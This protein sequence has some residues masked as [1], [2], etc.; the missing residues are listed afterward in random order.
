MGDKEKKIL[1]Y[2]A[3]AAAGIIGAVVL[4]KKIKAGVET[5]SSDRN[6]RDANDYAPTKMTISEAQAKQIAANLYQAMRDVGT[7]DNAIRTELARLKTPDDWKA[8]N[9]A[10]GTKDYGTYGAPLYSWLPSSPKTL[11]GWLREECSGDL[12]AYIEQQWM[13]NGL[14]GF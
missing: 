12:L 3:L 9:V 8:V 11:I 10:F 6:L 2:T 14:T 5:K 7:D 4:V 1:F 13:A